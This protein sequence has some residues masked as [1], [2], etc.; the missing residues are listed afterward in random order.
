MAAPPRSKNAASHVLHDIRVGGGVPGGYF[1]AGF[2]EGGFGHREG[3]LDGR[4][5]GHEVVVVADQANAE[6]AAGWLEHVLAPGDGQAFVIVGP[7]A[8]CLGED[9][10]GVELDCS[11]RARH[12]SV[13]GEDVFLAGDSALAAVDG[14]A[15][16]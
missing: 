16:E 4:V 15:A 2:F 7:G 13:D 5:A 8:G 3:A 9:G 14:E 11:Q 6:F 12:R 10:F 1:V